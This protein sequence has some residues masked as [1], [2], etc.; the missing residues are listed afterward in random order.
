MARIAAKP[1]D[2]QPPKGADKLPRLKA[3]AAFR[4]WWHPERWQFDPGRKRWKLVFASQST[5][6]GTGGVDAQGRMELADVDMQRRGYTLLDVP[7]SE[8]LGVIDV[9]GGTPERPAQRHG[10]KWITY[11]T[12]GGSVREVFDE[13]AYWAWLDTLIERKIVPALPEPEVMAGLAAKLSASAAAAATRAETV[14]A[15]RKR[16]KVL[17]GAAEAAGGHAPPTDKVT[18]SKRGE[19]RP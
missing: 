14:P 18:D 11:A 6:P 16:A 7:T 2:W 13:A 12:A 8:Y 1:T 3:R 19:A 9:H 4:L 10:H 15:A 5:S 17:A